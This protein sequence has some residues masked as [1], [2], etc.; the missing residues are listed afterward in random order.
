MRIFQIKHPEEVKHIMQEIKVDPY[1]I[2]IMLPKAQNYLV[3][4]NAVSSIVANILK[5]EMLSLGGEAA[6]AREALTGR[7][8]KTDCLLIGNLSQLKSLNEK[9]KLQPFG[10]NDISRQLSRALSYYQKDKF[11]L[12]AGKYSLNLGSRVRIMG[13]LNLTPDSFSGDGVYKPEAE[14]VVELAEKM[15]KDGADIIDIG[16]E[17]TRPGAKPVSLKEELS[18]VIPAIKVL[19]KKIKVPLSVDTYKP[20]VA[21]AALDNGAVIVNDITG[22]KN[23]KMPKLIARYNAGVVIMH[24]KG[25]PLTMQKGP[26]YVSLI[27]EIIAYLA[28]SI[29]RAEDAGVNREKIIID[30][31]IGFGKTAEH[32]LEILKCIN[33]FKVLGRPILAGPSRKS[34]IGKILDAAPAERVFGTASACVLL[35][36]GGAHLV[37]VHDVREVR[38]ALDIFEAVNNQ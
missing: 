20:E 17:S 24:S 37:R 11:T 14:E 21:K 28:N 36:G 12:R 31:G 10:L 2:G 38:Q 18:R 6:V 1:G 29:K 7:S 35:A 32:N 16:G 13:I 15:V 19:A 3:R 27:D 30:P 9:L 4:M 22:L 34:F 26:K 23:Y 25:K 8:K 5:Q 33:E